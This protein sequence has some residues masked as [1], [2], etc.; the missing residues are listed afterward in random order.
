VHAVLN[1]KLPYRRIY[2]GI[3][4]PSFNEGSKKNLAIAP[5]NVSPFS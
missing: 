1:K 3:A 5:G 4:G 2:D